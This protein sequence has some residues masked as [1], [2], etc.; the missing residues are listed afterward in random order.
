MDP[1]LLK[2]YD[3][4]VGVLEVM[5]DGLYTF[6]SMLG[7]ILET[8][9]SQSESCSTFDEIDLPAIE[10]KDIEVCLVGGHV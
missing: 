1:K 4:E 3:V 7:N 9:E 8:P 5:G 10:S 6:G 2:S